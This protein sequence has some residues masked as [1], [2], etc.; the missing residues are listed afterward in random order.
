MRE[1]DWI[2]M[3]GVPLITAGHVEAAADVEN[4]R[5][6]AQYDDACATEE[7]T[8]PGVENARNDG[9]EGPLGETERAEAT[10]ND[11]VAAL[12]PTG[13]VA[14]PEGDTVPAPDGN[15]PAAASAKENPAG[16]ASETAHATE[17]EATL[18]A[19][20]SPG[21]EVPPE[22]AA[23]ESTEPPVVAVEAEV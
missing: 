23:A 19:V 9:A 18:L 5:A 6:G 14:T 12:T 11:V 15:A 10:V 1:G 20:S 22:P 8:G 16:D 21:R 3:P 13:P 7:A 2:A 4:D 17:L